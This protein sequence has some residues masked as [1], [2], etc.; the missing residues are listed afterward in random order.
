MNEKAIVWPAV[1]NFT[2]DIFL[3]KS[4]TKLLRQFLDFFMQYR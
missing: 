1:H 4:Q 3:L 2:E